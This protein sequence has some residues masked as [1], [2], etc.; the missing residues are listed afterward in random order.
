MGHKDGVWEVSISRIG[1]PLIGTASADHTA[2]VWGMNSG[3]TT[4]K[5]CY[6]SYKLIIKST[7]LFRL[8]IHI[9]LLGEQLVSLR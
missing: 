8:T 5:Q 7:L 2:I 6:T 4:I 1:L 3:E 9:V